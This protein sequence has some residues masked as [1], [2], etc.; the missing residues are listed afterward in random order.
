MKR[1]LAHSDAGGV[2][3]RVRPAGERGERH[4]RTVRASYL[5]GCDGAGSTVRRQLG[6]ELRGESLLTLRQAL[7]HCPELFARIPIGKGRHYHFADDRSS[8][9]IVQ[10]DTRHF[11]LHAMVDSDSDMPWLFESLAGMAVAYE[12]VYVGQWTQRLMLADRFRDRRVLLAGDA[13]HLVIPTGGLG[14]NT[15][16]GDAIDLAWKLA[17]TLHGWGGPWL[18]ESYE[19]ERRPI[20]ARNVAASRKAA[21]GRR[22]WRA[23]WR[24]EITADSAAGARARAD[25]AAVADREQRWSND[26]LGIELGY[27]YANS[28]LIVHEDGEG[29]DP[30]SFG[31]TPTTWPGA[32]LPHIWLDD[33]T[34]ITDHLER[35]FTLLHSPGAGPA[36]GKLASAFAKAGAPFATF[37]TQIRDQLGRMLGGGGFDP[38]RDIE[39]ITVN[40]WPHGYAPEYNPLFDPD[41][42]E[43]LRPNVIGRA[44]LGRIA[45]ANSDAGGAAYTDSAIAQA[46]RAV[47]ELLRG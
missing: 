39:A 29:P 36:A 42:P 20:G 22:T 7:F 12:T 18:L 32:R 37:E 15:G 11:S 5:V 40:R 45:I 8:F 21:R 44:P 2:T 38:A 41:G 19:A 28:P 31:Y 6:I 16:V 13:A 33:G 25:L 17:G 30:D 1:F 14:M 23:A 34:A 43:N 10:D 24:P 27:R 3:A 26:L 46:D 9:L 4:E 35:R 47:N